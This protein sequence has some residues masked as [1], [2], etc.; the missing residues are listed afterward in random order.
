MT[1]AQATAQSI[2]TAFAQMGKQ[3]DLCGIAND[4][5]AMGIHVGQTRGHLSEFPSMILGV[6]DIAPLTMATAYAGFA[7]SGKVCTPVAVTRIIGAG[8]R[9]VPFTGT[10]CHQ[11][12]APNLANTVE[13]ALRAVLQPG[14][15]GATANPNDGVPM[16]AKTGTTDSDV[17]NWLVG[18]STNYMSAIWEGNEQGQVGLLHFP[19]LQGTTG[20]TAKF[21]IAHQLFAALNPALGGGAL[22]G[23]DPA[24]VGAVQHLAP[25]GPPVHGKAPAPHKAPAPSKPTAPTAPTAPTSG[26][27]SHHHHHG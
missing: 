24:M 25:A 13:Y 22:P 10:H 18:G 4:A 12:I 15:T 23:P 20:Y 3:L 6:N 5:K 26:G 14:G 2:N 11:A 8:N 21:S 19:L 9:N 17:E 16:F 27:G 1:V 7:D